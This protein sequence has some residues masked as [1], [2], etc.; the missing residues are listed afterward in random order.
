MN[1]AINSEVVPVGARTT[2]KLQN[3]KTIVAR[4]VKSRGQSYTDL[5]YP[6]GKTNAVY[7]GSRAVAY[8]RGDVLVRHLQGSKHFLRQPYGIAFA[9]EAI[10]QANDKGAKV[11]QCAD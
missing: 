8:V 4:N 3:T 6:H 2:S 5:A 7:D 9:T 11:V 1:P 10:R